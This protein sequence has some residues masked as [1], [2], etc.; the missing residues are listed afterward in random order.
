[1]RQNRLVHPLDKD[2]RVYS[3]E[4]FSLADSWDHGCSLKRIA[5]LSGTMSNREAIT[6][7][8][9]LICK[10]LKHAGLLF[11]TNIKSIMLKHL[12]A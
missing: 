7:R 12:F 8:N 6:D 9:V 11:S 1:V 4:V 2:W 3:G 10:W 5:G